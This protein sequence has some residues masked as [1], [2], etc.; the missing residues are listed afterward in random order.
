MKKKLNSILFVDDDDDC[1][2]FHKKLLEKMSCVDKIYTVYDGIEAL[3]FLTTKIDDRFPQPNIIF[4]DINM[5]RMN[6]LEFLA[7]YEKL[8]KDTNLPVIIMVTT[9]LN[10]DDKDKAMSFKCVKGFE[11]KYLDVSAISRILNKFFP[12]YL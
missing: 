7:E 12:D 8:W 11:N 5:P 2:Y 1:N 6:G 3:K 4:L 10:P 9:S